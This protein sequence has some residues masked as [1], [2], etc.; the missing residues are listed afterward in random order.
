VLALHVLKQ[1]ECLAE[2]TERI[3]YTGFA[4]WLGRGVFRFEKR[5]NGLRDILDDPEH[6]LRNV[7]VLL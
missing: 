4:V 5:A 1:G 6:L 3:L 2:R 7:F